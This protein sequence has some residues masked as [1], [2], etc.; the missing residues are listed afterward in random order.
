MSK[1]ILLFCYIVLATPVVAFSGTEDQSAASAGKIQDVQLWGETTLGMDFSD[2]TELYP[3][4][5][6]PVFE[7]GHY[8]S[9][10]KQVDICDSKS[11][12]RPYHFNAKFYFNLG[13]K[14]EEVTLSALLDRT[15]PKNNDEIYKNLENMLTAKYGLKSLSEKTP[16]G[17]YVVWTLRAKEIRLERQDF[18]FDQHISILYR[19][20]ADFP[21][22][23]PLKEGL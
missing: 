17:D 22:Q 21:K 12:T 15:N 8:T 1:F 23:T 11:C 5:T 10:I 4:A 3:N 13:R 6:V 7:V 19:G 14:L 20:F 16:L 9:I 18:M 2:F